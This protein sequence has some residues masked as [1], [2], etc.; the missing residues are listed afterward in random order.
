MEKI[1]FIGSGGQADE[2]ESYLKEASVE[3]RA[4]TSEYIDQDDPSHI[5]LLSPDEFQKIT[6]VVAAIGAPGIRR[7]M[8]EQWSGEHFAVIKSEEAYVD[9]SAKIGEGS[10]LGPR[11]ILTTNV[12]IGKHVIVNIAST[13][14]YDTIVGNYSTISP[15]AHI[16]G[17][18][19][20]G[21]GV[22]IGIGAIVSNNIRIAEGVVVGAGAVVMED[23]LTPN[24]VVVGTPARQI[25]ANEGWLREV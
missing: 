4:L 9:K 14:I 5:D 12:E 1:G 21:E 18:V 3:F 11:S 13:I 7:E 8:I 22:F 20:I 19:N 24:A 16:A 17:N 6:P 10:I 15:G 2:A 23:I 25:S